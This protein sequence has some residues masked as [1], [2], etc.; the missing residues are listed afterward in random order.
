MPGTSSFFAEAGFF[1]ASAKGWDPIHYPALRSTRQ[2]SGHDL[3]VLLEP[4]EAT[5]KQ[6]SRAVKETKK[7]LPYAVGS[8][9]AAPGEPAF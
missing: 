7:I 3:S 4:S 1:R 5:R 6:R 8:R 9:A 2:V